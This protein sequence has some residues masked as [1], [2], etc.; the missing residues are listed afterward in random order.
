MNCCADFQKGGEHGHQVAQ[1][2]NVTK[3][4]CYQKVALRS[5]PSS[6]LQIQLTGEGIVPLYLG[7]TMLPRLHHFF[8][9]TQFSDGSQVHTLQRAFKL[10]NCKSFGGGHN[11]AKQRSDFAVVLLPSGRRC[12]FEHFT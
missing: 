8:L 1:V 4:G 10:E 7:P 11:F 5:L 2:V 6:F 3:I 9:C 12:N